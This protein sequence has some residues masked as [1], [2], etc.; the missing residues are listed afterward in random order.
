MYKI[1]IETKTL[2]RKENELHAQIL[3]NLKIIVDQKIDVKMGYE[4]LCTFCVEEL[5]MSGSTAFRK[6]EA[7]RLMSAVPE[8]PSMIE[9]GEISESKV[10]Q[11]ARFIK[12]EKREA[13]RRFKKQEVR[14]LIH[15]VE[16]Q[17]TTHAVQKTLA[18]N[19]ILNHKVVPDKKTVKKNGN[20][21]IEFEADE[22]LV[23]LLD[24][25]RLLHSHKKTHSLNHLLKYIIKEHLSRNHPAHKGT[26]KT[27]VKIQNDLF[28]NKSSKSAYKIPREISTER[29]Q[30]SR[31]VKIK[32]GKEVWQRDECSCSYI[33]PI[34][35]R[36]CN[37][38]FR[39]QI[40]H[41]IP[42]SH[43]GSSD[44]KNLRLLCQRHNLLM[45]D[46]MGLLKKDHHKQA[47]T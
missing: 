9:K 11:V 32:T 33:D 24:Q 10:L 26:P 19:S 14:S 16:K 43:S 3:R 28:Q 42:F 6:T 20:T 35:G 17:K 47:F 36:R 37:S 12:D 44:T 15:Q 23:E 5:R 13:G 34:T 1:V 21:K 46:Q 41:R 31:Y 45:A 39:L 2:V 7:L 18:K 8:L 22:E 29:T 38:K 27:K 30:L 25:V 40:D 4:S